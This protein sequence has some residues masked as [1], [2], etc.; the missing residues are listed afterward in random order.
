LPQIN[1][2]RSSARRPDLGSLFSPAVGPANTV[3]SAGFMQTLLDGGALQAKK[4]AAQAS[5]EQAQA[6]YQSASSP[7][8]AMSPTPC[9][10]SSTTRWR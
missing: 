7:P 3:A 2:S 10:P 5:L 1:L 6:Q 4:R 9:A 8:S